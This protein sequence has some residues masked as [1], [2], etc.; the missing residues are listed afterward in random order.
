MENRL[1]ITE[2]ALKEVKEETKAC[3]SAAL[4]SL[5]DLQE[6]LNGSSEETSEEKKAAAAIPI[7]IVVE[8]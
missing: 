2:A 4:R 7:E 3:R 5:Q 1:A 6:L 8:V